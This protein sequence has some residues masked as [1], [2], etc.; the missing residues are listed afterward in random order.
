MAAATE[1]NVLTDNRVVSMIEKFK[2][3]GKYKLMQEG[4]RY[5]QADND[6]KNRK[7]TRKVD[8]HKEEET[9]RA[10][11]KLAHAKYK[12]QVDE[13]IAYLLTKAGYI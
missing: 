6:I 8:G 9:W 4:E 5:Y 2:A 11:N 1:S 12:I 10:N 13:K 3:S 7:I